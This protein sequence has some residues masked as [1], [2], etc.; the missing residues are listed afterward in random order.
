MATDFTLKEPAIMFHIGRT[1][2]PN[3][4]SVYPNDVYA[5][6]R[7]WWR[8]TPGPEEP[9]KYL[10]VLARNSE[11]ILGAFRPKLWVKNPDNPERWAFVGEPAEMSTQ[12]HYV[13]KRVPDKFKSR[14]NP[15]RFLGQWAMEP[16][17][18]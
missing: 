11:I 8:F 5:A 13:G 17:G 4:D 7:G 2:L 3:L 1:L 15:V 10:L 6:V 12:I 16:E 9:E 14:G 18:E